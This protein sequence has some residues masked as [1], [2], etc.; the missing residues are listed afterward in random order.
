M[1]SKSHK[2]QRQ[3]FDTTPGTKFA[4]PEAYIEITPVRSQVQQSQ[5][6]KAFLQVKREEDEIRRPKSRSKSDYNSL[7]NDYGVIP[8]LRPESNLKNRQKSSHRTKERKLKQ[9]SG[10]TKLQAH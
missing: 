7:S 9:T 3:Y 4:S 6:I 10:E 1:N 5:L 8:S 2:L